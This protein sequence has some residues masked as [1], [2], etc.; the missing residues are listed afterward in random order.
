MSIE[1]SFDKESESLISPEKFYE[2]L[3]RKFA[4]DSLVPFFLSV[5]D[6]YQRELLL[7]QRRI[8]DLAEKLKAK[9]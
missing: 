8:D 5:I 6:E 4:D 2:I 9:E 7:K 1:Q 3:Y